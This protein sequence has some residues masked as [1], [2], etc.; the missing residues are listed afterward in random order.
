MNEIL[1]IASKGLS[2]VLL[3]PLSCILLAAGGRVLMVRRKR[4]G[5]AL[6]AFAL[7]TLYALSTPLI[8]AALR[9]Q[10]ESR[11]TA[12]IF[13]SQS[14]QAIVV[15]GGGCIRQAPEYGSDTVGGDTLERLRWAARL[16]KLSG[17]PILAT[18]GKTRGLNIPEAELMRATL[19][20]DFHTPVRWVEDAAQTTL[21]NAIRSR[22]ILAKEGIDKVLLVTHAWHMAR[23]EFAFKQ[24]GFEV[25]P[26]PTSFQ[27]SD[28]L[29]ALSFIASIGGLKNSW[30]FFHETAGLLWYRLRFAMGTQLD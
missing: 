16:R 9:G 19:S 3:P 27:S 25:L 7:V 30:L 28:R 18:G 24:A 1:I 23:A 26:A 5:G 8:G 14:A 10:L 15:L 12:A 21:E 13:R 20:E 17:L 22:Q 29:D 11:S 2:S 6:L 4:L